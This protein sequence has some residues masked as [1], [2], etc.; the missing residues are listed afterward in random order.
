MSNTTE[1]LNSQVPVENPIEIA[2]EK[3]RKRKEQR[4]TAM[5]EDGEKAKYETVE[6]EKAS[7]AVFLQQQVVAG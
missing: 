1:Y 4:E 6:K 5:I 3:R 7:T 2:E